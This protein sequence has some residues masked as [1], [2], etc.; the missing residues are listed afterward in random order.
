VSLLN[1]WSIEFVEDAVLY[2]NVVFAPSGFSE[3]GSVTPFE[4]TPTP[5]IDAR[6]SDL[7][8]GKSELPDYPPQL[9]RGLH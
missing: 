8:S 5:E 7:T 4:G 6:W 9:V 2:E 3:D 1:T